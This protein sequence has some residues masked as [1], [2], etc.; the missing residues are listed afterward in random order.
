MQKIFGLGLVLLG[1][2]LLV[3]AMQR[4]GGIPGPEIIANPDPAT[5]AVVSSAP[6]LPPI[7]SAASETLAATLNTLD[8]EIHLNRRCEAI[9][10]LVA[11]ADT[12][13]TPS[14]LNQL[15]VST[16]EAAREFRQQLVRRW[17]QTDPAAA[18]VW[19]AQI[20][21]GPVHGEALEQVAI[22]WANSDFPAASAWLGALREGAGKQTATLAMTY[23]AARRDPMTALDLVAG[24][25]PSCD[26]DQALTHGLSQWADADPVAA[27]AW[28]AQVPDTAL[29]QRLLGAL[30]VSIAERD[31]ITAAL[32]AATTLNST[33][34]QGRAATAIAQR[35]AQTA[36]EEAA[37]W[38]SQFPEG[39]LRNAAG[40]C[41]ADAWSARHPGAEMP[42]TL[43]SLA[44]ETK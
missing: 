42:L 22:A 39:P 41:A 37:D 25:E 12:S 7:S 16:N 17:A 4:D 36:P 2:G 27:A 19:A 3:W 11:A 43:R 6:S 24:L 14:L 1:I 5:E 44:P 38:L 30:A 32:V 33:A 29:R 20:Q 10:R 15:V 26:R 23:E 28:A 8:E 35:W 40:Q 13:E 18:S 21:E 34:E 9:Q 31:G